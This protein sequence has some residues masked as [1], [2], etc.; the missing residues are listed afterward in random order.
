MICEVYTR[1]VVGSQD[2]GLV[3]QPPS[4]T[5]EIAEDL[6]FCVY[7]QGRKDVV[8]DKDF[9]TVVQSSRK[10]LQVIRSC[11]CMFR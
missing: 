3:T 11:H 4:G 5:K 7:V 10:R 9:G 2:N 6:L 1:G 8:K